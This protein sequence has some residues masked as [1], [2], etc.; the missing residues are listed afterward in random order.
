MSKELLTS[1]EVAVGQTWVVGIPMCVPK[2]Q[3][4]EMPMSVL[5]VVDGYAWCRL[6]DAVPFTHRVSKW[7]ADWRLQSETT[8]GQS[9]K[10]GFCNPSQDGRP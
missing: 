7:H 8:A 5:A 2:S 9:D 6:R 10:T 3:Q 1:K 4:E